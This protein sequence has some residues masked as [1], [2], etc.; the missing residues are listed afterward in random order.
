MKVSCLL[1]IYMQGSLKQFLPTWPWPSYFPRSQTHHRLPEI[2]HKAWGFC[3]DEKTMAHTLVKNSPVSAGDIKDAGLTPRVGRSP[4]AG[5]G[6]PLLYSCLENPGD[7]GTWQAT[8][9][10]V[11]KSQPRLKRF[12]TMQAHTHAHTGPPPPG[13]CIHT[14]KHIHTQRIC[15]S[16]SSQTIQHSWRPSSH[17]TQ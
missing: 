7:R 9:H 5:H 3:L 16:K 1:G 15:F 11:A 2:T 4:G 8:F 12:S 10:G 6:S 13:G 17:H 14:N